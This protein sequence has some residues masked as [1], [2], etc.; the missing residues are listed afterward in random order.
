MC[1]RWK[2]KGRNGCS[3]P[4]RSAHSGGNSC[5]GTFRRG[6]GGSARH[7]VDP[8]IVGA[9][10]GPIY[11]LTQRVGDAL[12]FRWPTAAQR[13]GG[14]DE[15]GAGSKSKARTAERDRA[16]AD[17]FFNAIIDTTL[18]TIRLAQT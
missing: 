2:G 15:T 1:P 12:S 5:A 13:D 17:R 9:H 14:P 11:V 7:G 4:A 18:Q 10:S 16:E 6:V 3:R 8:P